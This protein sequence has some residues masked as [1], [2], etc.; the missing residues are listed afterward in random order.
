MLWCQ[1]P[2]FLYLS[3]T[4]YMLALSFDLNTHIKSVD[5]IRD[6]MEKGDI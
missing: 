2:L 4:R 5:E 3:T 6:D 1:A